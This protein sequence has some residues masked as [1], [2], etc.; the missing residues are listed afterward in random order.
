M[1]NLTE[2]MIE[3]LKRQHSHEVH[4][5]LIYKNISHYLNVLGFTNLS[6]Y[7]AS[8]S[9][10]ETGHSNIIKDFL[11][12]LNIFIDY[13][14]SINTSI[15]D[16][17]ASLTRFAQVTLDTENKT[18]EMLEECLRESYMTGNTSMATMM[19]QDMIKE[20]IEETDKANTLNDQ[21]SN[22]GENRALMQLYDMNFE[23]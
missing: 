4:N 11:E 13:E 18:T 7:Y 3:L 19:L 8:W 15:L 10:E 17:G 6:K 2:R 23:S 5:S 12:A 16:L 9:V 22:I 21:I 20:Q 1:I 14:V